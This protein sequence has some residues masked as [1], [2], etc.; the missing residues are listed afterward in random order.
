MFSVS[1]HHQSRLCLQHHETKFLGVCLV[2]NFPLKTGCRSIRFVF[3][4]EESQAS[5]IL[6]G[7]LGDCGLDSGGFASG[8]FAS[9]FTAVPPASGSLSSNLLLSSPS[10]VGV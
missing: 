7:G 5:A 4:V 6:S 1:E 2:I 3:D 8:G 9:G 10:S